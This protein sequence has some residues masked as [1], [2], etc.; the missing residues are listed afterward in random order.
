MRILVSS[1]AFLPLVGGLELNVANVAEQMARLGHE[2]VVVC[3]TPAQEEDRFPFRVVRRPGPLALVRWTR[4]CEVFHQANLSLKE[5]WPLA[6]VRRPWVVSHHSW[7]RQ[8]DGRI[9]WRE[10][11]KRRLLA[12]AEGSIAV[13]S[14]IAADLEVPSEIVLNPYR[15]ELFRVLP[16]AE[17]RRELAFLGRLVSDKGADVLLDAL[18]LLAAEGIAPRLS[19]IGDG[20]ER[21]ALE[22]QAAAL[23]IAARVDFLGTRTGEELVRLLNEHLILAVPSRYREPFG[24]VALEGIACGCV[25]VGSADGG[26][27]EAIGPCGETVPNGDAPALAR[28]IAALLASPERRAARLAA[29]PAH[30]AAHRAEAVARRY[31]EVLEAA[32]ARHRGGR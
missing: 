7:Y 9:G 31:V 1:P 29:A 18:A 24:I 4:W 22:R 11:L 20:P 23:G 21:Q 15:D 32:A 3:R 27:A 25:V 2:V 14:V 30:L 13:S 10:R 16:G 17:R 19:V 6:F 28:A 5:L 26:L 12:R 8:P